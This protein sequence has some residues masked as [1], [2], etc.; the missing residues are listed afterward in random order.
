MPGG[1]PRAALTRGWEYLN[2]HPHAFSR[3]PLPCIKLPLNIPDPLITILL[4]LPQ[5]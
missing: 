2:K 4:H 3:L 5:L 1:L